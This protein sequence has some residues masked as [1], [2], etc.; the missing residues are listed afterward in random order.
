MICMVRTEPEESKEPNTNT[1]TEKS[2][3]MFP[4]EEHRIRSFGYQ[5]DDIRS[6]KGDCRNKPDDIATG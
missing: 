2:L 6:I 4:H 5:Q 3:T 1:D